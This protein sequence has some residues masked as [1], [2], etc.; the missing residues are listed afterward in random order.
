MP[1]DTFGIATVSMVLFRNLIGDVIVI[2]NNNGFTN[3]PT[4]VAMV[5]AKAER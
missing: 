5:V 4:N 1:E 3:I 2:V